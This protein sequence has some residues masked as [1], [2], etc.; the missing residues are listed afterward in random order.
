[1][2]R[3]EEVVEMKRITV[4]VPALAF[5]ILFVVAPAISVVHATPLITATGIA[6]ATGP[7]TI[8]SVRTAG[9]NT[10]VT[11]KFDTY[12]DAFTG[13][14]S[15]TAT[16]V[17]RLILNPSGMDVQ[18]FFTFTGTVAGRSGTCI[19]KFEGHGEG[20]GKPITGTWVIL[21]GTGD[22]ANLHGTLQVEGTAGV[23]L[24]YTGMI[25]FDP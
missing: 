16:N 14:F 18:L 6:T 3:N 12:P 10:F 17:F 1:M 25:H 22:L 21:S 23:I 20:I 5:L 8:T 24:Y 13:T 15:G 4:L 11:G 2:H 7:F 9:P 19:I